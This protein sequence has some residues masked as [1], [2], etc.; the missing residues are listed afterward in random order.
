VRGN[1]AGV[2]VVGENDAVRSLSRAVSVVA[3]RAAVVVDGRAVAGLATEEDARAALAM[4]KSHYASLV[5]ELEE[6]PR[7]KE[8]VEVKTM[9]VPTALWHPNPR[10]AAAALRGASSPDGGEYRVR[11][12]DTAS[13]IAHRNDLSLTELKRLNSGVSLH[14]LRAGRTLRVRPAPRPPLTVVVRRTVR[15]VHRV[16]FAT[17]KKPSA[18]MYRGKHLLLQP[19]RPGKVAISAAL[20]FEN[21][22]FAGKQF[23]GREVLIPSR[24]KVVAVGT[25]HR[26]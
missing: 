13:A 4:V 10:A 8:A 24:T 15:A 1:R 12:G 17:E 26:G 16:P 22:V 20:R 21:G 2:D 25:R 5:P 7:F 19:G 9:P 18:Q 14:P 6:E 11:P 23:V 3:P